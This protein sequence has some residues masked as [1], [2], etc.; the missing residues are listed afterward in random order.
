MPEILPSELQ[1]CKKCNQ[2]IFEGHA[3]ELGD[4]RWHIS[5]FK[6]SKCE[7]SLGCN[8]NFLVLGNGNLICSNCSYNCKQCNKKID[9]LA[10]LTGDQ[11]YCSSCFKC[12]SC[13]MKIE[14]LR[15]ARTSKG[16]FCM[17]CHEKLMA[18]KKKY[19]ARKKQLAKQQ[20][21]AAASADDKRMSSA[22]KNSRNSILN[23]YISN[24]SAS[25]ASLSEPMFAHANRS[26]SSVSS[27][28]K[29]L[30]APPRVSTPPN[31]P[32]NNRESFQSARTEM[33]LTSL[34][35]SQFTMSTA[36]AS[37]AVGLSAGASP[38]VNSMVSG[39]YSIE[40]VQ[41]SE[42]DE[43]NF[44]QRAPSLR[45]RLNPQ[46]AAAL[47]GQGQ[48]PGQASPPQNG[49]ARPSPH[50][51]RSPQ[52]SARSDNGSLFM[53]IIDSPADGSKLAPAVNL[54]PRSAA[55]PPPQRSQPSSLSPQKFGKNMLILSPNQ[56]QSEFEPES[57]PTQ[58][59][60]VEQ[61]KRPPTS[62]FANA[63]RRYHVIPNDDFSTDSIDEVAVDDGDTP[64]RT[65]SRSTEVM[66]SPPPRIPLPS[67]PRDGRPEPRP[68]QGLGLSGIDVGDDDTSPVKRTNPTV[69][70]LEDDQPALSRKT[71]L[72]TPKL[73]SLKHKRSISGSGQSLASKLGLFKAKDEPASVVGHIRH[74]SLEANGMH[75][76]GATPVLPYQSPVMPP[77]HSRS[78]SDSGDVSYADDPRQVRAELSSL[79]HQKRVLESEVKSLQL[80]KQSLLTEVRIL[81]D[82]VG[83]D[84]ARLTQEVAELE[85]RKKRLEPDEVRSMAASASTTTVSSSYYDFPP[86]DAAEPQRA[87]RLKFWKRGNKAGAP[88]LVQTYPEPQGKP[89]LSL[90]GS[91]SQP[92]LVSSTG[93]TAAS[94]SEPKHKF[95]KSRSSNILESF[96][97]NDDACPLYSSTIQHRA[98]YERARV[99]LIITKCLAEVERRGL[100]M[101]GIYRI[102][103]GNSAIVAIENAFANHDDAKVATKLDE[104]LDCDINAV[105]S[106]LKRYLRKLPDPLIPFALY[107]DF[108]KV[109]SANAASKVDK[110][111]DDLRAKVLSRLPAANM[112]VLYL[113]CKHLALVNRYAS[114]NRMGYKNLSVV[115][116]PTIA[117]DQTGEKEMI[118]MG[119][120]NNVT[121]LLMTHADTI[122]A[123][124]QG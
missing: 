68:A 17:E 48:G 110:R 45:Q 66:S 64:K 10:I 29:S 37:P 43:A 94:A 69:T 72:R 55:R 1:I 59:L 107:D 77:P 25:S 27:K 98:D 82:K 119:Y 31:D 41:N 123:D 15:Y 109:S 67:T 85:R 32:Y 34:A 111:I 6:C 87:A 117:R 71:S 22:S 99:P 35:T 116:A 83:S 93:S 70:S 9:D 13:K 36:G 5:C 51:L 113:L 42:E 23:A 24:P 108:V 11:A 118:D 53:D 8:S 38:A 39:D 96:L 49:P 80:E 120:R 7:S 106:A 62:P 73:P 121:E 54:Q 115:F 88:N 50:A 30:P 95:T 2:P 16:L 124:Y 60:A 102:S 92:S 78:A 101:E 89:Y 90:P 76:A 4:D 20:R 52:H 84:H 75:S 44:L 26:A 81:Q 56:V 19:D 57:S 21:D 14:D 100:D 104:T 79:Q 112:H 86:D 103:G 91:G 58:A 63:N 12:R 47:K 65:S 40:E 3:Y 33:S 97:G 18:K 46:L 105:T 28:N 74:P 61:D 122:F 114:V